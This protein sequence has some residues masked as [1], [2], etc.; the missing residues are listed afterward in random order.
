MNANELSK[1]LSGPRR[2]CGRVPAAVRASAADRV[3]RWIGRRRIG[4]SL[5]CASGREVRVW[6]DF[7][8]IGEGIWFDLWCAVKLQVLGG[9][10]N[11]RRQKWAGVRRAGI[12][13]RCKAL[14][15][16]PAPGKESA[17]GGALDWSH[18]R[19]F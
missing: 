4:K 8:T 10:R 17:D 19:G 16:A 9:R 14:C 13:D 7:T 5:R 11:A 3:A 2:V 18:A 15:E 6:A 1:L 12:G